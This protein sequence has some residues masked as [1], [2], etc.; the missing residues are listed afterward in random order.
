MEPNMNQTY[1]TPA[2]SKNKGYFMWDFIGRTLSYLYQSPPDLD[3]ETPSE[4][5][6]W[7]DVISRSTLASSLILDTNCG[8]LDMMVAGTYPDQQGRHPELGAEILE[9]ARKL[10]A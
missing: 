10:S 7:E 8:M 9:S 5:E 2:A 4:R 6:K 1:M 3:F